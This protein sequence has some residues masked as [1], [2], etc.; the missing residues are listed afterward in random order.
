MPP[1]RPRKRLATLA[2]PSDFGLADEVA[3]RDRFL[4]DPFNSA[5]R[6]SARDPFIMA[7]EQLK[8][9]T[10]PYAPLGPSMQVQLGWAGI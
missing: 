7:D 3:E 8:V 9:P 5:N 10:L 2:P 4:N 1:V 6:A